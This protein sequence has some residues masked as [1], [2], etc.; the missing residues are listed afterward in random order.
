LDIV[1]YHTAGCHLCELAEAE[2]ALAGMEA[3]KIDIATDD[4][5]FQKYGWLIPVLAL[6]ENELRWPFNA[7]QLCKWFDQIPTRTASTSHDAP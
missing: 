3:I 4:A 5:L 7:D 1:L 2:L 6:G